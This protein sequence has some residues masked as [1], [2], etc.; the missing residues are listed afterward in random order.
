[1][2]AHP[3]VRR[4]EAGWDSSRAPRR[5]EIV[6]LRGVAHTA[7]GRALLRAC[8]AGART[9]TVR[10]VALTGAPRCRRLRKPRM[11]GRT[12]G[13]SPGPAHGS[14]ELRSLPNNRRSMAIRTV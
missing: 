13:P 6:P 14:G 10:I 3:L 2:A 12:Y 1:A 8:V 9:G 11:R 4:W 7:D 5:R